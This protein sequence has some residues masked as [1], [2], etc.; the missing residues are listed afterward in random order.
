MKVFYE[1]ASRI[2]KISWK[3]FCSPV[4]RIKP[5]NFYTNPLKSARFHV[6]WNNI[7]IPIIIGP[8][9]ADQQ[10]DLW[11]AVFMEYI[12]EA[13]TANCFS[14]CSLYWKVNRPIYLWRYSQLPLWRQFWQNQKV[15]ATRVR[16]RYYLWYLRRNISS[17]HQQQ[18]ISQDNLRRN[19]WGFTC[20]DSPW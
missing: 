18:K 17:D 4:L 10:K 19:E 7:R 3:T 15:L 1:T 5:Q 9:F 8:N 20:H 2:F 12:L 6:V 13:V 14:Q 11:T 16:L